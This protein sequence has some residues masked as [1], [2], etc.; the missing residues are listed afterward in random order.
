M[1]AGFPSLDF[2]EFHRRDLPERLARGHGALAAPAAQP[3]GSLA[4]RLGDGGS[5]TYVPEGDGIRIDAGEERA[6]TVVELEQRFWE[7]LVH[8]LESAPGLLYG[9]HAK[10]LRGD[11][12]DF[13]RWE[14]ALRAMYRGRPV[15]DPA[16]VDL[17]GR[18][19]APLDLGRSFALDDDLD[20]MADFLRV[21]GFVRVRTVFSS[22][23]VEAMLE[24]AEILRAA[25]VEDDQKSWWARHESGRSV[26]CRVLGAGRRERLGA[27]QSDPRMERLMKLPDGDLVLRAK[28]P[29]E[30]VSVLWKQPGIVEGLGD[31]P[32]HRDC[33]MGGHAVM[34]PTV[35]M[36]IHLGPASPES[37]DLRFL[38][39]SWRCS[40]G[41][42][43]GDDPHAA[44]GVSCGA[45]PGDVTLHYGDAVH[46]APPPTGRTGPFRT[47]LL[48]GL[49]RPE[50]A[51]HRGEAHY[52][53][54]LFQGDN[55]IPS[56]RE[57]ARRSG[58]AEA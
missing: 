53:D 14:P 8:D 7:G 25:A 36:S 28:S 57:M 11:M 24:D 48:L 1:P 5:Y 13:V 43:E 4:F 29:T 47:T 33:G 38:P 35:V 51:H 6:T 26:V 3:L 39:G 50:A 56:M 21:T 12:M 20:A 27:L 32:W 45:L 46:G 58:E 41:F 15:Y 18:D 49:G 34:C 52:N 42:A 54:A 9:G 31:L 16:A 44:H 10:G 55:K 22:D 17:T 37:G 2:H 19:G 23:E 40:V 30:G